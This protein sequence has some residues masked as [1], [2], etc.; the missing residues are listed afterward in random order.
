MGDWVFLGEQTWAGV[1][2]QLGMNRHDGQYFRFEPIATR[3]RGNA[4]GALRQELESRILVET[5][6]NPGIISAL[7][8]IFYQDRCW[9]GWK[10]RNGQS[11]FASE[12]RVKKPLR[13]ELRDL[14]QLISS[15]KSWH[16]LGLTVGRP[17]W[18]RLFIDSRGIF[19]LDPKPAF[20]LTQPCINPPIAL[21]RCRP[22]EEYHHLPSEFA[23]DIFYLG[24]IIYYYLTGEIPFSLR[25]GWPTQKILAGEIINPQIY[26]SKVPFG[27]ARLITS[28]LAPEPAQRPSVDT[29]ARLWN[30]Y[31]ESNQALV[32]PNFNDNRSKWV[33]IRS[34][35]FF[36]AVSKLAIPL[37]VLA[38][39]IIGFSFFHPKIY[40]RPQLSPLKTAAN[41]Y[42]EMGRINL[43]SIKGVSAQTFENDFK[44]AAKRRLEMVRTILS[45][46][47]F[48]VE[49]MRIVSETSQ[50]A[51][52]EADLSWW[53]WSI[54]GW[55]RRHSRERLVFRKEGK[56]LKLESREVKEAIN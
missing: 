33:K 12:L 15:Y 3:L 43:G 21:E 51:I 9:L 39:L 50:R 45:K 54:E 22:A 35:T 46:P 11:L 28:M 10:D 4:V 18:R 44:V 41:F 27:L 8:P 19:M 29:I 1:V 7:G 5:D 42:Q 31:L 13:E 20:Y 34:N 40:N 53:E 30:E 38:L 49:R 26:R 24:L 47:V 23:G 2:F 56:Q 16:Q 17:D 14:Y 36:K 32:K 55:A 52:I 37:S 48:E 6:Q 25:K